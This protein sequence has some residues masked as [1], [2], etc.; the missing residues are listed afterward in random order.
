[1]QEG[2]SLE[3]LSSTGFVVLLQSAPRHAHRHTRSS[4]SLLSAL[5]AFLRH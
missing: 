1:M 5:T 3:C 2:Q 4:T